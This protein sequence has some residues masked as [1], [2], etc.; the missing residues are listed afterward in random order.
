VSR[1]DKRLAFSRDLTDYDVWRLETGGKPEL[2]L[3]STAYDR[4]AQFSPDG[5]RIV[6]DSIPAGSEDSRPW[7]ANADGAG[8]TPLTGPEDTEARQVG[9][10]T[11]V[12]SLSTHEARTAIGFIGKRSQTD[13]EFPLISNSLG[14][15][16]ARGKRQQPRSR[17]ASGA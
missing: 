4:S 5:R 8:L 15:V 6:F 14:G 1:K 3:V 2:F 10:R 7:V 17:P 13:R 12:G 11:A 16:Y 9:R